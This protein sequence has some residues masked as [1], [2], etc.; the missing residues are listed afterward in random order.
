MQNA[1]GVV[2]AQIVNIHY[3]VIPG[4]PIHYR[5]SIGTTIKYL[6][7]LATKIPDFPYEDFQRVPVDQLPDG[8]WNV[9]QLIHDGP[10]DELRVASV[11]TRATR[12]H[13]CL[14]RNRSRRRELETHE[15]DH[16]GMS[17]VGSPH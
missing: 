10:N 5:A 3:V 12:C 14:V 1:A 15:C 11:E 6:E 2:R 4:A 8:N 16:G 7:V 13:E 9:A 17:P